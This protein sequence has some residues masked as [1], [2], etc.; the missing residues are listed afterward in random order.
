MGKRQKG[1]LDA[2]A[3]IDACRDQGFQ[4]D[5]TKSGHPRVRAPGMNAA[6]TFSGTP[7]DQRAIKNFLSACRRLGLVYP[8]PKE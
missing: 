8:P 5:T 1:S 4:V 2:N 6:T 7:G 3:I